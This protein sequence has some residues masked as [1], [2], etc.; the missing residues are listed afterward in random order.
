M[1][2]MMVLGLRVSDSEASGTILI[3]QQSLRTRRRLH[4]AGKSARPELRSI[5]QVAA[6]W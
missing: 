5:V 2:C 6:A 1:P 4:A 3:S